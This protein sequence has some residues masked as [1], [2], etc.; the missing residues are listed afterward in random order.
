MKKT[1]FQLVRYVLVGAAATFVDFGSY[2]LFTRVLLLAAQVANPLSYLVGNVVS[3]LGQ[4]TITFHS[5]GRPGPQYFRFLVVNAIGLGI[6]QLTLLVF[7]HFGISDLVGKTAG[8]IA[9]GSFNYLSNRFWTFR[10]I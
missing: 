3:F 5:N 9:S 8:V 6:S 1:F 2:L 7:L 4:R 10:I